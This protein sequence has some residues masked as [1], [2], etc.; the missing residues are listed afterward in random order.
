MGG[1]STGIKVAS[2]T[3]YEIAFTYKGVRC[4]ERVKLKPTPA[5]LKRIKN[6]LAAINDAIDK[7]TFDYSITFPESKLRF[8]F[9]SHQGE[10]LLVEDYLDNWLQE[11]ARK[12]K[13]SSLLDYTKVVNNLVIPKFIGKTLTEIKRPAIKKWL[14]EMTCGNK[15]LSNIQSILRTA[16]Q[17]AVDDELIETNPMY[18]WKYENKEAPKKED[19]VQPFSQ[20][21]QT[22]ILSALEGQGKNMVQFF[23][24]TGLRT[25][26]L[27]ALD[28]GDIDWKRGTI[29]INKALTQAADDCEQPKTR[30][31]NRE[32]KILAPALQALNQQKQYTYL[33]NA[34]IFQN[35]ATF[36]RWSGDQAIRKNVWIYAL[37]RAKVR[38]RR[39]YQ[40]RHTYAS[41]MLTAG[42]SITWLASQM[43]HSDWGMLRK[44]YAKF[45]K[46][47]IP[48]AGNKAVQMF[49]ANVVKN[50][51]ISALN[52]TK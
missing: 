12:L 43:G 45:I 16:L 1:I 13:A 25:S 18:G 24:W 5:N 51:V 30:S 15:R 52:S 48:D 2:A 17:D 34:E 11:K 20:I 14:L 32:V 7:E 39:P 36:E 21:E 6:H 28:W 22:A 29:V 42:E 10:T 31:G 46:D 4:R 49:S 9:T 33:K 27:V 26:E 50:V 8:K 38:Y 44:V 3:S 47:S 37:K 40:T 35:P 23:F 19:D 41:M